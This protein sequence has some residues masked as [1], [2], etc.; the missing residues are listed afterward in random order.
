M[1]LFK[2]Q[3]RL[4]RIDRLIRLKATGNPKDFAKKLEISESHL[5]RILDE[6]KQ[7]GTPIYY[8]RTR[9]SYC[10]KLPGSF[11]FGFQL[12]QKEMDNT[13]GGKKNTYSHYLR[14]LRSKFTPKRRRDWFFSLIS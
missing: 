8:C 2:Y 14:V 7:I 5:F 1:N 13:H 3:D 9:Q 11:V 6:M 4:S 10:Y 12:T